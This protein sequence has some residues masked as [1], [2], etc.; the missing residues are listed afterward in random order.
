MGRDL[1]AMSK[2][3]LISIIEG[4]EAFM[5]RMLSKIKKQEVQIK[6]IEEEKRDIKK[7]EEIIELQYKLQTEKLKT[8]RKELRI[9]KDEIKK[10]KK[11]IEHAQVK[12]SIGS[13]TVIV[14]SD[15][16]E[17]EVLQE[18]YYENIIEF[19]R[20][21][22]KDNSSIIEKDSINQFLN[23][24]LVTLYKIKE[25]QKGRVLVGEHYNNMILVTP[26]EEKALAYA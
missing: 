11:E 20:N 25:T 22:Y 2:E 16:G 10:Y 3:Q 19:Q 7:D 21:L 4:Q 1:M 13:K 8:A 9:K 5:N 18:V 17:S 15:T 24:M 23:E 14:G 26:Y 12:K 6:K